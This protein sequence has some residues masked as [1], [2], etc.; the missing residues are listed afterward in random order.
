MPLPVRLG[1]V[2]INLIGNAIKFTQRGRIAVE[3]DALPLHD[4]THCL[5]FVVSDTGQGIPQS[6][7]ESIFEAFTQTTN[8]NNESGTGL[9]LAISRD[10]VQKMHGHIH[11]SSVEGV[12]SKIY[13]TVVLEPTTEE[14]LEPAAVNESVDDAAGNTLLLVEDNPINRDLAM[15]VLKSVGYEVLVA[16]DGQEALEVLKAF[17]VFCVLMDLRMPRMTGNEAIK[18]IRASADLKHLNV[19]ALSAGVLQHEIDEALQNGFDHYVT[20]PVDFEALLRLLAEISGTATLAKPKIN[21]SNTTGPIILDVDFGLAL[22]NHDHDEYLLNRLT[23]DFVDIYGDSANRLRQTLNPDDIE[24]AERLLHNIAGVAGSFGAK[25]LMED[26][27][28]FEHLIRD[29]GD[30][31]T[32]HIDQF[33]RELKNLVDAIGQ[34]HSGVQKQ[35]SQ[36]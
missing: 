14:I 21:Q 11:A 27:R 9:G 22:K 13:F 8:V 4:G 15:E 5:N 6:E 24:H 12:G 18:I 31:K 20:K 3:L 26:C 34:Y 17:P 28:R 36:A 7:L 33:E 29:R 2:L 1:Q 23:Q 16:G 35:A 19:I 25:K 32:D 10:L 30:L